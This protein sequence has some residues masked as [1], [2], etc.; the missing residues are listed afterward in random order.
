MVDLNEREAKVTELI[1]DHSPDLPTILGY[2][3][4]AVKRRNAE[5]TIYMVYSIATWPF[6]KWIP[7]E[8]WS[9]PEWKNRLGG[10][11]VQ[12]FGVLP[13]QA[14]EMA[15]RLGGD[16]YLA[17]K[18]RAFLLD[19][20]MARVTGIQPG[21][22]WEQVEMIVEKMQ[23]LFNRFLAEGTPELAAAANV[24]RLEGLSKHGIPSLPADVD[25]TIA[26]YFTGKTGS[27]AEQKAAMKAKVGLGGRRKTRKG[28]KRT[29]RRRKHF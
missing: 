2:V 11:Y 9:K 26:S 17:Y 25:K 22:S 16:P 27:L 23:K 12:F 1:K 15:I 4:N 24:G 5:N 7:F 10:Q 28:K 8:E 21:D 3:R 19:A 13:R 20:D 29:T 18:V 6:I 14:T